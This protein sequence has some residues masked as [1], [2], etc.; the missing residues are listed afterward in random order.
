[1][2]ALTTTPASLFTEKQVNFCKV[3]LHERDIDPFKHTNLIKNIR[4]TYL[5]F[6]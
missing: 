4:D 2:D 3:H 6:F 1:V 5:I